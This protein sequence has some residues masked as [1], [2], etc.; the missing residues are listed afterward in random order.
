M[1]ISR[2]PVLSPDIMRR[3]IGIAVMTAFTAM[4]LA[5]LAQPEGNPL[6]SP[7]SVTVTAAI[8]TAAAFS[9]VLSQKTSGL[10]GRTY[11]ALAIGLGCWFAG[12]LVYS[13]ETTVLQVPLGTISMAE[14]P[15]IATFAFFGYYVFR[16]YRF[17]GFAAKGTHMLAV[18]AGV[19]LM[20]GLTT[21]TL[22]SSFGDGLLDNPLLLV[23]FIYPIGDAVLIAPSLLLLLTLRNGLLT[24]TPWLFISIGLIM[25]AGAD[26]AFT[27][28]TFLMFEN[29]GAIFFPLYNAGNLAFAG[30]LIWH[31]KFGIYDHN[32]ALTAFQE[33]NR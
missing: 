27:N 19:S 2:P 30:A 22:M 15:W 13:Y 14:A 10:Y 32:R 21:F 12:E 28:M 7:L 23:R 33:G 6:N 11:L 17:F 9:V 16:T 1:E 31:R 24:Y 29:L 4:F 25:I 3:A 8:A 20:M 26:I 5:I 18:L